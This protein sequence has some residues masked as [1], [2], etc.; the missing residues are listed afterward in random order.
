MRILMLAPQG[1]GKGT[2]A[3]R[4]AA[5]YGIEHISSGDLLRSEVA[6]GSDIG[7][8]VHAYLNQG[9]LVPDDLIL[10][11]MVRRLLAAAQK[12][13]VLDGWPRTI[14]QALAAD[15]LVGDMPAVGLQAVVNLVVPTE[16]LHRRL[17]ARAER[18]DRTDDTDAVIQHRLDIYERETKPLLAYYRAQG[19]LVSVDGDQPPEVV[20]K[21]IVTALDALVPPAR[22]R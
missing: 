9:D 18:E 1:A 16:E 21:D 15:D 20:T 6:R 14:N 19:I 12:G 3:A 22:R 7:K 17:R 11:M 8:A 2:Q 4:L 13:F 5:H 10:Q